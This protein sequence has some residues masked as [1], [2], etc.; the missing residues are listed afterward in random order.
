MSVHDKQPTHLACT[1]SRRRVDLAIDSQPAPKLYGAQVERLG[2][3]HT[4]LV[5]ENT[6]DDVSY[7]FSRWNMS[8]VPGGVA[9]IYLQS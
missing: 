2:G 1:I 7:E 6:R 8:P 9:S 5:R 3:T 4:P